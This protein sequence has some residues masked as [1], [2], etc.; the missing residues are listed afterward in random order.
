MNSERKHE[1][2]KLAICHRIAQRL[3]DLCRIELEAELSRGIGRTDKEV[4]DIAAAS[5]IERD[6]DRLRPVPPLPQ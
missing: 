1:L 4:D 2:A 3:A 6:F 5:S